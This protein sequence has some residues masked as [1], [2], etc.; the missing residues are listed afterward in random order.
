[1]TTKAT[2]HDLFKALLMA[3]MAFQQEYETNQKSEQAEREQ[4][5]ETELEEADDEVYPE[6]MEEEDFVEQ[7]TDWLSSEGLETYKTAKLTVSDGARLDR[8]LGRTAVK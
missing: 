5:S 2:V 4:M 1:M 3:T 8:I 7:F 6:E